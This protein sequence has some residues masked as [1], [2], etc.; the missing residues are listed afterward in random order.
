M[1]RVVSHLRGTFLV[2]VTL[3]IGLAANVVV[4]SIAYRLL[5]APPPLVEI[6][7]ALRSLEFDRPD[8]DGIPQS[9]ISLAE[10]QRLKT[11]ASPAL[12]VTVH[13]SYQGNARVEHA[14]SPA[15]RVSIVAA[16]P[17]YGRCC[18]RFCARASVRPIRCAVN[19]SRCGRERGTREATRTGVR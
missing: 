4:V 13:V 16:T 1:K 12:A 6:P 18:G 17:E 7:H 11:H 5:S 19:G 3:S 8:G 14:Q 15:S 2:A 9:E 10:S